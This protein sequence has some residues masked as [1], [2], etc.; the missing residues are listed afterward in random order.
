[1]SYPQ[2]RRLDDWIARPSFEES[3]C[4]NPFHSVM[5]KVFSDYGPS[6]MDPWWDETG[7]YTKL[8][9]LIKAGLVL[10][11]GDVIY[12]R[13]RDSLIPLGEAVQ[14]LAYYLHTDTKEARKGADVLESN[15][16]GY[17]PVTGEAV[18]RNGITL[19][20]PNGEQASYDLTDLLSSSQTP[21][22]PEFGK[23]P[24]DFGRYD[25]LFK[26]FSLLNEAVGEPYFF[27][28]A[29][30]YPFNQR[31]REKSFVLVGKGGN[32]KSLFMRMVQRLYQERALTDA[33]Q[34][35][36][37]GHDAAVIAYNFIGKRVVTFNDVG[38]PSE[39]FLE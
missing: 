13:H 23:H 26:F 11:E 5:E 1:M 25:A 12:V 9:K 19:V 17:F 2:P 21:G 24:V 37:K 15:F 3:V 36:F 31:I 22:V 4:A 34:P 32:G 28:R 14:L 16:Q 6:A 7:L 38:D 18:W 33:P 30:M 27:E 29:L 39:A 35:N 8:A 10:P 20:M